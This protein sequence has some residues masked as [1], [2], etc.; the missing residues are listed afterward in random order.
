MGCWIAQIEIDAAAHNVIDNDV[1]AWRTK[2]YRALIFEG[3]TGI[4]KLLK[5]ALVQI[6]SF[7]L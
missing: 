4:L 5:V 7:T 3:V 6:R 2:A 1:F